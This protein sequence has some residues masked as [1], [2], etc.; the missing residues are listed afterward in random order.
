MADTIKVK[1]KRQDEPESKP[2]WEEFE[3]PYKPQHNIVSLLMALRE[4]PVNTK[5][6]TVAPVC[7]EANCMEEV[8]GA[9]TMI[10][11][12]KVRQGCSALVDNLEQPIVLEPMTKFPVIRDLMVDRSSMFEA[13]KRVRAWVEL[14]GGFDTHVHA[15]RI[16]PKE[17]EQNYDYSRCMTCGCCMEACPQVNASSAFIGPAPLAQVQLFN[18]LP[19][20]K[21]DKEER[22]HAIMGDGGITDCGNAQNCIEACP[23]DISLTD[24]IARLGRDTTIQALKDIFVK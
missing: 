4:N 1:I 20:G 10:I 23:K 15:P 3:L 22:L 18:N 2:Y 6:E 8:C 24:A 5:G 12:G 21:F 7:Y 19:T 11:N 9:C 13:L 17:W 16:S 14:D